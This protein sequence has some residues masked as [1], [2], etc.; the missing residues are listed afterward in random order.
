MF[1]TELRVLLIVLGIVASI[2]GIMKTWLEI[3]HL[4]EKRREKREEEK[5][6][7]R[8]ENRRSKRK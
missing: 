2:L 6:Q 5:A 7:A 3:L 8:K 4:R 1:E